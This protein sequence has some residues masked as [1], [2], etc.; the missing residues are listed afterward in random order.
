MDWMFTIE[1]NYYSQ[2]G[3]F[4]PFEIVHG[5]YSCGYFLSLLD[6]RTKLSSL[7]V[8][9]ILYPLLR[10]YNSYHAFNT[11]RLSVQINPS[12]YYEL[13]LRSTNKNETCTPA[14]AYSEMCSIENL[15]V[16]TP[17]S[18]VKWVVV[19]GSTIPYFS[20]F[21]RDLSRKKQKMQ[22]RPDKKRN[23]I[24]RQKVLEAGRV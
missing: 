21:S 16:R 18:C 8:P 24:I 2:T 4:F 6:G 23:K 15:P 14:T 7:W 22:K 9:E 3:V 5:P 11:Y 10:C 13:C 19:V 12:P 1:T 20:G 17:T